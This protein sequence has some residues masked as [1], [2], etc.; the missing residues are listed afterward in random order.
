[1]AKKGKKMADVVENE[2][3]QDVE[4]T[5]KNIEELEKELQEE[6]SEELKEQE[7][8]QKE[9]DTE[10]DLETEVELLK[11]YSDSNKKLEEIAE[12]PAKEAEKK[13]KEEIEK[14]TNIQEELKKKIKESEEKLTDEQKKAFNSKTFSG[15]WNG[16]NYGW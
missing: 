3:I 11:E 4:T 15:F 9:L 8:V 16:V 14:V 10:I 13:I 7:K 1:M 12:L 5:A 6:Y 2:V